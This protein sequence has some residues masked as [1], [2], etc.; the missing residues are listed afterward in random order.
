MKHSFLG[1]ALCFFHA[2]MAGEL[3][4][5]FTVDTQGELNYARSAADWLD[6]GIGGRINWS[7][8]QV[9]GDAPNTLEQTTVLDFPIL[10]LD[11]HSRRPG[12]IFGLRSQLGLQDGTLLLLH[13]KNKWAHANVY[14]SYPLVFG[15]NL[16][17]TPMLFPLRYGYNLDE[18][19]HE[20]RNEVRLI[21]RF[22]FIF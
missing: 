8:L 13:T 2:A 18:N 4:N 14:V 7:M 5:A 17:V 6:V 15:K 11:V 1:A 16:L 12:A 9:F 3:K 10:F 19:R 22:D 21:V 20:V